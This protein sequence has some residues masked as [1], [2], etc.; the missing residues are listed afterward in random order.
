LASQA[1]PTP[2]NEVNTW[3][4][5]LNGYLSQSLSA[6]GFLTTVTILTTAT[7]YTINNGS[8][9]YPTT[10]PYTLPNNA[11]GNGVWTGETVLCYANANNIAITLPS[12]P[13]NTTFFPTHTIKRTDGNH[14][15]YSVSITPSG[16]AKIDGSSSTIYLN[17]QYSSITLVSDG[18]NWNII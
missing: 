16:G 8:F 7:T 15:N 2:G 14:A 5:Y 17:V 3:G 12:L 13:G 9:T 11:M 6:A 18:T 1:L 4:S 10:G